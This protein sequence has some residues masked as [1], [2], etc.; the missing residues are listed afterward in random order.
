MPATSFTAS[1]QFT[2]GGDWLAVANGLGFTFWAIRQPRVRIIPRASL[3]IAFTADSKSLLSCGQDDLRRLPLEA[4]GGS[5]T[6]LPL[7]KGGCLAVAVSPDGRNV[8]RGGPVGVHLQPLAGGSGRWLLRPEVS[9]ISSVAIDAS[10]RYGAAAPTRPPADPKLLRVWDLRSGEVVRAFP[11]VPPGETLVDARDWGI[12]SMGFTDA[13]HVVGA[14]PRGVRR[15]DLASGRSE[16]I[17]SLGKDH[18]AWIAVSADGRSAVAVS[19]ALDPSREECPLAVID[20]R[21]GTR[22]MIRSH[23]NS[24]QNVAIDGSGGTIATADLTGLVRVGSSDGSAPHLLTGG[25]AMGG[26]VIS[27]D[28]RW[29]AS[30]HGAEIRLWPMP[31]M[32][33][34]PLHT[35]PLPELL[36]KLHELTNIELVG[37]G[38][39]GEDYRI[40]FGR[41]P[42]WKTP[43]TW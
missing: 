20:L 9:Q 1:G 4:A 21:D 6:T 23:G 10:G 11:L 34:P 30:A 2:P 43:P 32:S 19:H 5:A 16:W 37:A 15:F 41:F 33:K 22:R 8:L 40:E 12:N 17:W 14:G 36:A 3:R 7:E 28:G 31:D 42:G 18:R 35:L 39:P 38:S 24:V 25:G 13:G 27:P 29:I 26:V